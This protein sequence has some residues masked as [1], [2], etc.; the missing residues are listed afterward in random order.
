MLDF[1]MGARSIEAPEEVG[2]ETGECLREEAP[3]GRALGSLHT[4][5]PPHSNFNLRALP[6][7]VL[8]VYFPGYDFL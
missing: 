3:V 1:A 4:P 2:G 8:F 5:S 7:S 6:L